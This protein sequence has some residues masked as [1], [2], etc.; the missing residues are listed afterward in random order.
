M[1]LTHKQQRD[2]LMLRGLNYTYGDIADALAE[3]HGIDVSGRQIGNVVREF[4][5]EAGER[6]PDAVFDEVVLHGF[7]AD[8]L[9]AARPE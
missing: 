5:D 7:L 3:R 2:V 8:H 1:D 6:G 9:D 4:E